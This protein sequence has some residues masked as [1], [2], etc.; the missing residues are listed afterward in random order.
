MVADVPTWRTMKEILRELRKP[1]VKE[2]YDS[3][4]IDTGSI[5]WEKCVE[6]ICSQ[7]GVTDLGEIAWG[8]SFCLSV[9]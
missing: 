6:Y 5:A 8:K 9:A 7:H 2:K 3:V 1:L 4:I